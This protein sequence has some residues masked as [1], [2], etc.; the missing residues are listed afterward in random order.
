[1]MYDAMEGGVLEL[2]H[3][4]RLCRRKEKCEVCD[5]VWEQIEQEPMSDILT[6]PKPQKE[7]GQEPF[8]FEL[9]LQKPA[10]QTDP[11][12][13]LSGAKMSFPAIPFP[14]KQD[15]DHVQQMHP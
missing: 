11:S 2:V 10:A 9:P 13:Q 12:V 6:P 7:K 5:A 14:D 8:V 4:L 15:W 1:M 3:K